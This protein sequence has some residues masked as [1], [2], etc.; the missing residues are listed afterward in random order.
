MPCA[1]RE[2]VRDAR[3]KGLAGVVVSESV[4]SEASWRGG[5]VSRI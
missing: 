3:R 1:F 4:G 2:F 5:E